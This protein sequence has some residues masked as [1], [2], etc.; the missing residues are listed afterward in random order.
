MSTMVLMPWRVLGDPS[1]EGVGKGGA[2]GSHT[3]SSLESSGNRHS[4]LGEVEVL[5]A[6]PDS[7]HF[8][9]VEANFNIAGTECF[10]AV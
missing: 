10:T 4:V 3:G 9:K 7:K 2:Y 1:K 6:P 5:G 8:Q